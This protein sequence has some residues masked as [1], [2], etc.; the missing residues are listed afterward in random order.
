MII[1]GAGNDTINGGAGNDVVD[2]QGANG[3]GNDTVNLGDGNDTLYAGGEISNPSTV[4]YNSSNWKNSTAT[5]DN[6]SSNYGSTNTYDGGNGNDTLDFSGAKDDIAIYNS[7]NSDTGL[8]SDGSGT[9]FG[10]DIGQVNFKGFEIFVMGDGNDHLKAYDSSKGVSMSGGLGNDYLSGSNAATGNDFIDGGSGADTIAG[11]AGDDTIVFDS[12]DDDVNGGTGTDTF[13]VQESVD[14]SN[15]SATFTNMNGL[16]LHGSSSINVTGLSLDTIFNMSDD[17]A[18]GDSTANHLFN[19]FG[20]S[21]DTLTKLYTGGWTLDTNQSTN[22]TGGSWSVT[23]KDLST[24]TT[25]G[26]YDHLVYT[27]D[28]STLT[29]NIEGSVSASDSTHLT[30]SLHP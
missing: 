4:Y 26:N 13:V 19:I 24:T 3:A 25:T 22:T 16:D 28:S 12:L 1:G 8:S 30:Y 21:G 15:L 7:A 18:N 5:V 10:S 2:E 27:K 6:T 11:K 17:G 23:N 14:F 20:D 9:A 29:L